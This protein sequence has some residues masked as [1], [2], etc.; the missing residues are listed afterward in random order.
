MS[1]YIGCDDVPVIAGLTDEASGYTCTEIITTAPY[2]TPEGK[3]VIKANFSTVAANLYNAAP[4]P[5]V[6]HGKPVLPAFKM[7]DRNGTKV[8]VIGLTASIVP[9]Q[10]DAFNIGFRFTQGVEELPAVIEKVKGLRIS[11][12]YHFGTRLHSY[13]CNMSV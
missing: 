12:D 3:G 13:F 10:A 2:P 4:L 7:L 8:A 5:P 9:Q 6:L 1:G 11:I